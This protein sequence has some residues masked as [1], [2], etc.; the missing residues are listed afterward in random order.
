MTPSL[1]VLQTAELLLEN[2]ADINKQDYSG[3]T[4]LHWAA[5]RG[6]GT[7]L[8]AILRKSE[9][10]A[11]GSTRDVIGTVVRGCTLVCVRLPLSVC[12][13]W[14]PPQNHKK[15]A[16]IDCAANATVRELIAKE[17][18]TGVKRDKKRAAAVSRVRKGLQKAKIMGANVGGTVSNVKAQRLRYGRVRPRGDGRRASNARRS[19][20]AAVGADAALESMG[21]W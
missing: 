3:D 6:W 19:S 10:V 12:N 4:A 8:L 17:A 13:G 5:R 20:R 11:P 9:S 7:L 14:T 1:P 18:R 2:G 15:K 16:A 21:L